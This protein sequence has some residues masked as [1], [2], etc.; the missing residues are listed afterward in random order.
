MLGTKRKYVTGGAK[1]AKKAKVPRLTRLPPLNNKSLLAR[2]Q[3]TKVNLKYA[4]NFNLNPGIG[5]AAASHVFAANGLFDPDLT[6]AGHQPAGFD[7]YMALYEKYTVTRSMIKIIYSNTDIGN[8]AQA[9]IGVVSRDLNGTST[10]SRVYIENGG[11][12]WK[13]LGI[14]GSGN[15]I[16]TLTQTMNLRDFSTNDIWNDDT[17]SGSES[18]NPAETQFFIVFAS[19][20]DAAT[21]IG[22]IN[23]VVEITYEVYFRQP[24][25]TPLS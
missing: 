25:Q 15:D 23:C 24:R 12:D 16:Q 18:G 11:C 9:I 2:G 20:A 1:K 8:T 4:E 13:V 21:D 17:F 22:S 5:G 14:R 3:Y 19:A 10:D 6:L 7:S